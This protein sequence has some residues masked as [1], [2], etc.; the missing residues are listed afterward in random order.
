MEKA[1]AAFAQCERR[2]VKLREVSTQKKIQIL[3]IIIDFFEDLKHSK[4]KEKKLK[5]A[6]EK[7]TAKVLISIDDYF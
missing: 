3:I 6:L 7:E 4:E 5:K 1:K 2:D